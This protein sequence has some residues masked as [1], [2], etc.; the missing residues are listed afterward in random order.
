MIAVAFANGNA[1]Q[2]GG[3][4]AITKRTRRRPSRTA[5]VYAPRNVA[6]DYCLFDGL[7]E[8]LGTIPAARV[9][10][11]LGNNAPTLLLT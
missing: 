7:G 11:L 2:S 8:R 5:G 1:F 10:P 6:K 9:K 4:A 3:C